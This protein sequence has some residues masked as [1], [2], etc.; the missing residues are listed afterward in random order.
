[1]A[2]PEHAVHY[3]EIVTPHVEA[4]C[5]LYEKSF[6][7]DFQPMGPELGNAFVAELPGGTLCGVR[8]PMHKEEEPIVRTYVRVADVTTAVERASQLGAEIMLE[9]MEIPGHGIIAIYSHGGIQ[10]GIWQLP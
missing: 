6:G 4:V 2:V 1:M 9:R 3:L 5:D 10:H 8:A 7:W